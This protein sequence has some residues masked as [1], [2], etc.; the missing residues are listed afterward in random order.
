MKTR[1]EIIE[2]IRNERFSVRMRFGNEL[3]RLSHIALDG[4][5][6]VLKWPH[7]V[8]VLSLA[9]WNDAYETAMKASPTQ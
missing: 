5:R 2:A 8:I 9:D 6:V 7:A 4:E 3:D 1:D